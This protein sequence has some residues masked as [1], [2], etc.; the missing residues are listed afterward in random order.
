MFYQHGHFSEIYPF[1]GFENE[2]F[3]KHKNPCLKT[4]Q[5]MQWVYLDWMTINN[6]LSIDIEYI[7]VG[8]LFGT[9]W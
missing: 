3:P 9:E 6:Q 4:K 7:R 1:K 8:G 2:N 5:Q